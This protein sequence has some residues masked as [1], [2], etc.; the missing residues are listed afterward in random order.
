[1]AR[2]VRPCIACENPGDEAPKHIVAVP[3]G[4]NGGVDVFWHY[5]CHALMTGCESCTAVVKSA[6]G[7]K[8]AD[9]VEHLTGE[10][11]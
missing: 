2:Q 11:P 9:L 3:D 1:M 5:D 8:N 4:T 10:R 7:K 6:D